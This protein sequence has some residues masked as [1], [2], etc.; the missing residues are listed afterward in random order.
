ME[1]ETTI[2]YIGGSWYVRIPTSYTEHMSLTEKDKEKGSIP[3]R[4]KSEEGNKG[5][6]ASIWKKGT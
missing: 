4:I 3:G 2:T 1:S 5:K 6:Y